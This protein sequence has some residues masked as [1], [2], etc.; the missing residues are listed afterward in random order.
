[1]SVFHRTGPGDVSPGSAPSKPM[2]FEEAFR[3]VKAASQPKRLSNR[4]IIRNHF[5]RLVEMVTTEEATVD[6]LY[7][8]MVEI[9]EPVTKA[10]FA[11][12]ITHEIGGLR[13]TRANGSRR[14][15]IAP[16]I[17]T[18]DDEL[19]DLPGQGPNARSQQPPLPVE[20]Q[21]EVS[22]IFDPAFLPAAREDKKWR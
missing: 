5:E 6:Q 11:K 14:P 22:A 1:M 9:G 21:A 4:Q 16:S 3:R 8:T 18:V 7:A 13:Q 15:S 20:K 12:A 2:M 17:T 10:G 19:A